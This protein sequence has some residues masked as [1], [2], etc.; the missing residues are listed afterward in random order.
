MSPNL[1]AQTNFANKPVGSKLGRSDTAGANSDPAQASNELY[2]QRSSRQG[3]VVIR[4][5]VE[6]IGLAGDTEMTVTVK[7]PAATF[8]AQSC[9]QSPAED[10]SVATTANVPLNGPAAKN[11]NPGT[12]YGEFELDPAP[13]QVEA[14]SNGTDQT[15]AVNAQRNYDR[16]N[17]NEGISQLSP[18]TPKE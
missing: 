9:T 1:D 15:A 5:T 13:A 8:C 6:H 4:A 12:L 17:E 14:A 3:T 18:A 10:T 11:F 7:W 16:P 2:V